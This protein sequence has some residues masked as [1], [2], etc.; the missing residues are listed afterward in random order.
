MTFGEIYSAVCLNVWGESVPPTGGANRLQGN[1]GIISNMHRD[2]QTDYNYWFMQTWGIIDT[3]AG[4]QGYTLPTNFK[5][6]TTALW[7]VVDAVATDPYFSE[8]L[9]VLSSP[10]AH[11]RWRDNNRRTEYPNYYEIIGG[12][13][14]ILYPIPEYDDRELNI[15]YWRYLD[16]PATA[17]FT[18]DYDELTTYGAEAIIALATAKMFRIL[19]ELNQATIYDL[20]AKR[21]IELLKQEDYRR[22]QCNLEMVKY[23]GA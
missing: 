17:T 15:M 22:R 16:R 6:L 7:Q 18:T 3:V 13:T 2:I 10:E 8:P 11:L 9:T 21:Q 5:E 12:E 20:E 4:T 23:S 14:I 1:E 19:Q